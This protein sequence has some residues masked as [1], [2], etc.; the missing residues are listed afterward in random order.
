VNVR[1]GIQARL[2]VPIFFFRRLVV[3]LLLHHSLEHIHM[4]MMSVTCLFML[5][6][7]MNAKPFNNPFQLK[8]E[9]MNEG[10]LWILSY[11]TPV[12]S[13]FVNESWVRFS[14]GWV[15]VGICIIMV[16]VNL[17]IV[18]ISAVKIGI[19]RYRKYKFMKFYGLTEEPKSKLKAAEEEKDKVI[20]LKPEDIV[21][22]EPAKSK[23][24]F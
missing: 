3:V 16:L 12:F 21:F 6:Y 20:E 7:Y 23:M 15:F 9:C 19:L 22:P 24:T 2:V 11:F 10:F 4:F 5:C 14:A 18:G 8:M 17:T 1:K 13:H